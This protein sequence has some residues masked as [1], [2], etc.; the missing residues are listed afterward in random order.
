MTKRLLVVAIGIALA[1]A[2]SCGC[3][4]RSVTHFTSLTCSADGGAGI[5]TIVPAAHVSNTSFSSTATCTVTADA[6]AIVLTL[7]ATACADFSNTP[8]GASLITASCAI[9]PLAP[10][11]WAVD[12][13]QVTVLADGGVD[14]TRCS[15]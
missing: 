10:G 1:G 2:A 11:T 5:V 9:G 8:S 3:P 12:Q 7:R 4:E 6:G 15:R 13:A 14:L